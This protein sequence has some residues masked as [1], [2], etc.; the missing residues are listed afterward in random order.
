VIRPVAAVLVAGV[1][2][3][4]VEVTYGAPAEHGGQDEKTL[5]DQ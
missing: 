1:A 3:G 2:K 5:G 4:A